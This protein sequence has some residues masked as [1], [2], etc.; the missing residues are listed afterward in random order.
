MIKKDM[1]LLAFDFRFPLEKKKG[2]SPG[3]IRCSGF[4]ENNKEKIKKIL[5]IPTIEEIIKILSVSE[6]MSFKG[7]ETILDIEHPTVWEHAK[8]LKD[9]RIIVKEKKKLE[10]E[11]KEFKLNLR[12]NVKVSHL[13][14]YEAEEVIE[15]RKDGSKII[16]QWAT[17]NPEDLKKLGL[18]NIKTIVNNDNVNSFINNY[19]EKAKE[20]LEKSFSQPKNIQESEAKAIG[21]DI[22]KEKKEGKI[23]S[24]AQNT[25][26]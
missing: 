16:N 26:K 3:V 6:D 9:L 1:L 7:V 17:S 14:V 8:S 4:Y 11:R 15:E 20:K 25:Q 18:K 2:L 22:K 10:G 19:I 24:K 21:K 12:D 13:F 23:V 5:K